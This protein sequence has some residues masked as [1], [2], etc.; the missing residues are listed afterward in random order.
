MDNGIPPSESKPDLDERRS[1]ASGISNNVRFATV[2]RSRVGGLPSVRGGYHIVVGLRGLAYEADA[3]C[4][5]LRCWNLS[6]F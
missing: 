3:F 2:R 1:D 6:R 5:L 4:N